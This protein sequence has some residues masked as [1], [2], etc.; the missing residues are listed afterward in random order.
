MERLT[1]SVQEA[2]KIIGV[3]DT[4]MYSLVRANLVPNIKL[5][6][7]YVIP[8]TGSLNGLVMRL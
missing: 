2:A 5:G 8:K 3:S 7:R 6:K 4:K 1:F